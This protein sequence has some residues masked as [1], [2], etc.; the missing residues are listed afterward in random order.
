[1]RQIKMEEKEKIKDNDTLIEEVLNIAD[2]KGYLDD[3]G[4]WKSDN[5]R[6]RVY[7]EVYNKFEVEIV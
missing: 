7:L 3:K 2:E 4:N 6:N 5:L 1:M